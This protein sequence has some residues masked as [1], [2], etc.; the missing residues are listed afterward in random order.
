MRMA[1]LS[2]LSPYPVFF[3]LKNGKKLPG[4]SHRPEGAVLNHAIEEGFGVVL[5]VVAEREVEFAATVEL[6]EPSQRQRILKTGDIHLQ[7]VK[8]VEL[9]AIGGENDVN[10]GIEISDEVALVSPF[11]GGGQVFDG[12]KVGID[13]LHREGLH[14]GMHD[15][16]SAE[17]LLE[18]RP[19]ALRA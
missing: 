9:C 5:L 11:K 1:T 15:K 10:I 13:H 3:R 14:F 16:F 7:G 2:I 17:H 18:V 6:V 19:I 4:I 8:V 12:G